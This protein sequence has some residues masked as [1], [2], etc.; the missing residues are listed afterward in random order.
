[1]KLMNKRMYALQLTFKKK[2]FLHKNMFH[3]QLQIGNKCKKNRVFNSISPSIKVNVVN[4][5]VEFFFFSLTEK[6]EWKI[7]SLIFN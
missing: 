6:N 1:M 7:L 4:L 2:S 5:S 3:F